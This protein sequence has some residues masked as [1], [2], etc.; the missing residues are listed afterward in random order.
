MSE[1]LPQTHRTTFLVEQQRKLVDSASDAGSALIGR[2]LTGKQDI[3]LSLLDFLGFCSPWDKTDRRLYF[4]RPV[5][6]IASDGSVPSSLSA[7]LHQSAA[8]LDQERKGVLLR[9]QPGAGTTTAMR[10]AYFDCLLPEVG[11]DAPLGENEAPCWLEA[12]SLH[13]DAVVSLKSDLERSGLYKAK[14]SDNGFESIYLT[15]ALIG[16]ST[17]LLKVGATIETAIKADDDAVD[18]LQ[19]I[20]F[21]CDYSDS[22]TIFC[23]LKEF[24]QSIR[25]DVLGSLTRFQQA[26]KS[27]HRIVISIGMI[28]QN[29][30]SDVFTELAIH[31]FSESDRDRYLENLGRVWEQTLP[32]DH[33]HS[34]K[35]LNPLQN[36]TASQLTYHAELLRNFSHLLAPT[37]NSID[38]MTAWCRELIVQP[39]KDH[40]SDLDRLLVLSEYFGDEPML[41]TADSGA[42]SGVSAGQPTCGGLLFGKV[43]VKLL[44]AEAVHSSVNFASSVISIPDSARDSD[45]ENSL[46]RICKEILVRRP[47]NLKRVIDC[48]GALRIWLEFR[49]ESGPRS[50]HEN[51]AKLVE[52]KMLRDKADLCRQA[53]FRA[54]EAVFLAEASNRLGA[55]EKLRLSG[56]I[57]EALENALV[58]DCISSRR[59]FL[60]SAVWH[61]NGR[62]FATADRADGFIRIWDVDSGEMLNSFDAHV[63]PRDRP[64][65]LGTIRGLAFDPRTGCYLISAGLD[66]R[67]K[68]WSWETG[69]FLGAMPSSRLQESAWTAMATVHTRRGDSVCLVD[70]SGLVAEV[71]A[72][73]LRIR[74]STRVEGTGFRCIA[75]S[76]NGILA[77]GDSQGRVC[78]LNEQFESPKVLTLVSFQNQSQIRVLAFSPGGD[79]LAVGGQSDQ[80]EV[81]DVDSLEFQT[82]VQGHGD[83]KTDGCITTCLN[84][85]RDYGLVSSGGD[86]K[87]ILHGGS[88]THVD[89]GTRKVLDT[90]V[91]MNRIGSHAIRGF[92][93]ANGQARLLMVG[94][95]NG[96]YVQEI[97]SS[98]TTAILEG[99]ECPVTHIRSQADMLGAVSSNRKVASI[100]SSS[101][102]AFLR[103]YSLDDLAERDRFEDLSELEDTNDTYPIHAMCLSPT[104]DKIATADHEGRITVRECLRGSILWQARL[105]RVF[106]APDFIENGFESAFPN[107]TT[108]ALCW[109]DDGN[110]IYSVGA[111]SSLIAVGADSGSVIKEFH[112]DIVDDKHVSDL[113]LIT[114]AREQ[115]TAGQRYAQITLKQADDQIFE[116]ASETVMTAGRDGSLRFWDWVSGQLSKTVIVFKDEIVNVALSADKKMIVAGNAS[117]QITVVSTADYSTAVNFCLPEFPFDW[118]MP[119]EPDIRHWTGPGPLRR[120]RGLAIDTTS[121]EVVVHDDRGATRIFDLKDGRAKATGTAIDS[122]EHWTRHAYPNFDASNRLLT[123]DSDR[124]ARR[125]KCGALEHQILVL[126]GKDS[127]N[128]V[129]AIVPRSDGSWSA[130]SNGK[131]VH[132][133]GQSRTAAE[134]WPY[135]PDDV[136]SLIECDEESLL[137][138]TSF[139]RIL[140]MDSK[141][142]IQEFFPTEGGRKFPDAEYGKRVRGAMNN[143]N[144]LEKLLSEYPLIRSSI[145]VSKAMNLVASSWK[146]GHIDIW[147]RSSRK[148][149]TQ[150]VLPTPLGEA[151]RRHESDSVALGINYQPIVG[152][153]FSD[154][155]QSLVVA[156]FYGEILVYDLLTGDAPVLRNRLSGAA[157]VNSI[158]LP[159]D[160]NRVFAVNTQSVQIWSLATGELLSNFKAVEDPQVAMIV[161]FAVSSCGRYLATGTTDGFVRVWRETFGEFVLVNALRIE[162]DFLEENSI[163]DSALHDG[164]DGTNPGYFF[165]DLKFS[166][167]GDKLGI[168]LP[169]GR[170]IQIQ[171]P[172]SL[173]KLGHRIFKDPSGFVAKLTGLEMTPDFY[174]KVRHRNRLR[175]L[176]DE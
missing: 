113:S 163:D 170:L 28:D 27:K 79:R 24:D 51:R 85:Q 41:P 164:D 8:S 37:E 31:G 35:P 67:V 152:V 21:Y 33:A 75:S 137:V 74:Q 129:F 20:R 19:R 18:T 92:D 95:D 90:K 49:F 124:V 173:D 16:L 72:S 112:L 68:R 26:Y 44:Q 42:E 22:V 139:G 84:W 15:Y 166:K 89:F 64:P 176:L 60:E 130:V 125:W 4:P 62:I 142:E 109:S 150:F 144:T 132:R 155:M 9:G 131:L 136:W 83:S 108:V 13:R 169:D 127:T 65:G 40:Y 99:A 81:Y 38:A 56:R 153:A 116:I 100:S 158:C 73:D 1:L 147:E 77:V 101:T 141:N 59:L 134:S 80:I 61:P 32:S 122:P 126:S 12:P 3:S 46:R 149:I 161:A 140:L 111:D 88:S 23:D 14:E 11:A 119:T 29:P 151:R 5:E 53:K 115:D 17:G 146:D 48:Q 117:G 58:P 69:Q 154:P 128:G 159:I 96:I 2:A 93:I 167:A 76:C 36:L 106:H 114:S 123:L 107:L 172:T 103:T 30:N 105:H 121:R 98:K 54:G 91:S 82:S 7:F 63:I 162:R 156:T 171:D 97:D 6:H 78:L 10:H 110:R 160:G 145:C 45:P 39:I 133:I 86:G 57:V 87:V 25:D 165:R 118:S 168:V 104:G 94:C 47:T 71:D 52:A 43:L 174:V 143:T 66:G 50:S 34:L 102:D 138:G 55:L 157:A 135:R 148:Q 70:Y 120:I 175:K